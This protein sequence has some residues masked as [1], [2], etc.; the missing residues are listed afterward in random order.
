MRFLWG[1]L[2]GCRKYLF[3]DDGEIGQN[4]ATRQNPDENVDAVG[5]YVVPILHQVD[6]A[7]EIVFGEAGGD[8][9][10]PPALAAA[11]RMACWGREIAEHH[12]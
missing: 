6:G 12:A 9:F 5:F 11:M 4:K 2:G 1:R 8:A 7:V 3:G 10:L